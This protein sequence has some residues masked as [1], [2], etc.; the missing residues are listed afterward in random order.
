VKLKRVVGLAIALCAA[1]SGQAADQPLLFH[2]ESLGEDGVVASQGA[3]QSFNPASVIKVAT[4]VLALKTLGPEHKYITD[5]A[6]RGPCTIDQGRLKGDLVIIGGGD[7]DFQA[8]NTWLVARELSTLGIS[9]ISGDLVVEGVFFQGWEHGVKGRETDVA[10]RARL[11][12]GRFRQALDIT[13]WDQTLHATWEDA[14]PRH[15]W[16]LI[17]KPGIIIDGAIRL[18]QGNDAANHLLVQHRSN[19][20][21]LTLKRFNT[22]SNNDIVRVADPIGG[23]AAIEAMLN[24][25]AGDL[26]GKIKISTASGEG[27]NRMTPRQVTRL[28]RAFIG[29]CY[30][31]NL[32]LNDVLPIPGCVP[33]SLPLMFSRLAEGEYGRTAVV[34]SGTLTTTDGGVAVL[35]GFI[36][37]FSSGEMMAFCVGAPKA[38]GQIKRMRLKEQDWLLD[39]MD[40]VGGVYHRLCGTPLAFSDTMADARVTLQSGTD[41]NNGESNAAK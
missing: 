25:I 10:L 8:E 19:P 14:A 41:T 29:T 34:K 15:G 38:G 24:E 36:L 27:V 12:G 21:V 9:K 7:P 31:H 23:P 32:I 37:P 4:S 26:P 1:V 28:L 40:S 30:E 33:G 6:C 16:P 22:F 2:V 35:A 39:L 11:M 3:D 13:R 18:G 5:F 17:S 20:L